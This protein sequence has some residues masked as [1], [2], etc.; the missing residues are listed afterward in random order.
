[1]PDTETD[2][3]AER[4]AA[5]AERREARRLRRTERRAVRLGRKLDPR[6]PEDLEEIKALA[7]EASMEVDE[8]IVASDYVDGDDWVDRLLIVV[9][10]VVASIELDED[11]VKLVA[12][13]I[14]EAV[15]QKWIPDSIER[16]LA[17]QLIVGLWRALGEVVDPE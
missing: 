14:A 15:D 6:L 9:R 12:K 5:R 1:M 8:L 17:E 2:P 4:R 3:K 11:T 13:A 7:V 16:W 10:T